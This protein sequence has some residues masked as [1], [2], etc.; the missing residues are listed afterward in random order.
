MA[1]D[2]QQTVKSPGTKGSAKAAKKRSGLF[3]GFMAFFVAALIMVAVFGGAF[4][5]VIKNNINGL[6]ERYRKQIQ[7]IPVIRLALPAAPDPDDPK[8]L[9]DAQLRQKYQE[10]RKTR[11]DL[12]AQIKDLENQISELQNYKQTHDASAAEIEKKLA[13]LDE[14]QAALDVREKQIE[15]EKKMLDQAAAL[16]DKKAFAEYFE[17][18]DTQTAKSIYEQVIVQQQTDAEAKKFAS[19]YGSMD[20]ASAARIFENMGASQLDLIVKTLQNMNKEIAAQI[21]AAM[22]PGFAASVSENMAEPF[23]KKQDTTAMQ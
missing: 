10:L 1:N 22:D 3:S 7:A 2:S 15:E 4:F 14:R 17:K 18:I 13:D 11:D 8:Y 20:P 19:L 23:M 21:L 9:T 12:S 5:I 16:G 6:G